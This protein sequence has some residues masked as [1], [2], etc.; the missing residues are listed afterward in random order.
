M[1]SV[2]VPGFLPSANGLRFPNAFARSPFVAVGPVKIGDVSGGLCGGMV[3][4]V[5]DFFEHGQ[6]IP[7]MTEPPPGGTP[8]YKFIVHRLLQSFNLP[9]GLHRYMEL[10]TP[11]FPDRVRERAMIDHE[12]PA[13]RKQLDDGHLVPLG[14]IKVKSLRPR[15]LAKQHQVLTYG[16]DLSADQG[17]LSQIAITAFTGTGGI[18]DNPIV[19]G[20]AIVN[21]SAKNI[22][23]QSTLTRQASHPDGYADEP[24]HDGEVQMIPLYQPQR[25]NKLV[26]GSMRHG[27]THFAISSLKCN[28]IQNNTYV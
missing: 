17:I 18:G 21:L 7:S 2:R 8:L 13:I 20:S 4:V 14:L 11:L 10:M 6:S 22:M 3:Y 5:C 27:A 15:D 24:G 9:F 28:S 23:T 25:D 16:Y 1:E 12:W 26:C 19:H